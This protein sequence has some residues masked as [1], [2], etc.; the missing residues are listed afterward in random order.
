MLLQTASSVAHAACTPDTA[1]TSPVGG[2]IGRRPGTPD[3]LSIVLNAKMHRLAGDPIAVRPFLPEVCYR[4]DDERRELLD[5]LARIEVVRG[6]SAG[7][8]AVEPDIRASEEVA[9]FPSTRGGLQ[10]TRN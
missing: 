5:Q 6:E 7:P 10:V 2:M 3:R 1:S 8:G 4:G 9:K